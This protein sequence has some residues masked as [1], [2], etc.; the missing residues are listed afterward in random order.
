M[1]VT[2]NDDLEHWFLKWSTIA[3]DVCNYFITSKELIYIPDYA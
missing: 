3:D 2:T 1:V